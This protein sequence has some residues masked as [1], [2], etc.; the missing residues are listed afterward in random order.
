[1]KY[2]LKTSFSRRILSYLII[3][4]LESN[5]KDGVFLVPMYGG[6]WT[7]CKDLTNQEMRILREVHGLQR[8]D[9]CENYLKEGCKRNGMEEIPNDFQHSES[10]SSLQPHLSR[11]NLCV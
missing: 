4:I 5:F 6:I 11:Y 3:L 2:S 8:S 10:Q 1:M 9:A 7:L